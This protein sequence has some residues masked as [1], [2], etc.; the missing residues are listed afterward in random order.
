MIIP[1]IFKAIGENP[2]WKV[3]KSQSLMVPP[4]QGAAEISRHDG[5]LPEGRDFYGDVAWYLWFWFWGYSGIVN[6]QGFNHQTQGF[7]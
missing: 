6:L 2:Y 4:A 5:H 7:S 1:F 3:S